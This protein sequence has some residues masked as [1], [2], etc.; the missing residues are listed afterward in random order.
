MVALSPAPIGDGADGRYLVPSGRRRLVGGFLERTTLDPRLL[1]PRTD[2]R[3]AGAETRPL[4]SRA[5]A[6]PFLQLRLSAAAGKAILALRRRAAGRD[7]PSP[8]PR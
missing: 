7:R 4:V 6:P 3:V 8:L 2:A 1:H 5:D